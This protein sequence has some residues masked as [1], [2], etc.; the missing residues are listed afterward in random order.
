MAK[1]VEGYGIDYTQAKGANQIRTWG[2]RFGWT[3]QEKRTLDEFAT[4]R[5]KS[6]EAASLL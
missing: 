1:G 4:G 5:R 6:L 3:G 2:K